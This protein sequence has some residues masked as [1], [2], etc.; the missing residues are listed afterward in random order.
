MPPRLVALGDHGL[1]LGL[2]PVFGLMGIDG[3]LA[4]GVTRDDLGATQGV[5]GL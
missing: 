2:E 4:L 3:E 1:E 5:A